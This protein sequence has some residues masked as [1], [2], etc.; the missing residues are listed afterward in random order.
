[1]KTGK[2]KDNTA[3]K[4][5]F[6]PIIKPLQKIVDSTSTRAMKDEPE[7]SRD[8]DVGIETSSVPKREKNVS[9]T[10]K[11]K[12]ALLDCSLIES[13]K[14]NKLNDDDVAPLITSTPR[15]MIEDV[16]P[17][18]ATNNILANEHVF[19]TTD[20]SM[21]ATVVQDRMQMVEGQEALHDNLV[22]ST[23]EPF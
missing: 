9:K 1:L 5:H 2:V 22:K 6:K 4:R 16:Q 21:L 23:L 10:K 12:R 14:R 20:D 17:T 19:E 3:A 15:A 13:P 7:A 11:E 8:Y 18:T